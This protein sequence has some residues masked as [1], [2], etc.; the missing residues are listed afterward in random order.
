[1]QLLMLS[2]IPLNLPL[3]VHPGA[4][5]EVIPSHPVAHSRKKHYT[6][7]EAVHSILIVLRDTRM[8][9]LEFLVLVLG[10]STYDFAT[11]RTAFFTNVHSPKLEKLLDI[12]WNH[13]KGLRHIEVFMD[14]VTHCH[15]ACIPIT[16]ATSGVQ[17]K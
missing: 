14:L 15:A 12:I 8:P 1:M 17:N 16:I 2:I 5:I 13:E 10:N 7:M 3:M 9:P 6:K 4:N 11:Y